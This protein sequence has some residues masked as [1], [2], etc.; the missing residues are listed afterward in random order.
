M[1][2]PPVFKRTT[3]GQPHPRTAAPSS[4]EGVSIPGG[5]PA[6]PAPFVRYSDASGP[7][8][9]AGWKRGSSGGTPIRG[10]P[11]TVFVGSSVGSRSER[12][13]ASRCRRRDVPFRPHRVGAH[14]VR[15]RRAGVLGGPGG[16]RVATVVHAVEQPRGAGAAGCARVC[17]AGARLG[18]R[19]AAARPRPRPRAGGRAGGHP[20]ARGREAGRGG[21]AARSGSRGA[22]TWRGAGPFGGGGGGRGR[23][24][25]DRD[26]GGGG[27]GAAA[28]GAARSSAGP[29]GRPEVRR[30][31]AASPSPSARSGREPDAARGDLRAG[32]GAGPLEAGA[33]G[34]SPARPLCRARRGRRRAAAAPRAGGRP[35]C[36][37]RAVSGGLPRAR[38][39]GGGPGCGRRWPPRSVVAFCFRASENGDEER[40]P[41]ARV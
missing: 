19:V 5:A 21:A 25:L 36:G 38:G 41:C 18:E 14:R 33:G 39:E 23:R 35:G 28:G 30:A 20:R 8:P 22:V 11:M 26:A 13:C 9:E 17:G 12:I 16:T 15:C 27:G 10:S 3:R 24:R 34:P 32:P 29:H 6:T 4:V 31:G 7:F 40:G 37:P 1:A 2:I